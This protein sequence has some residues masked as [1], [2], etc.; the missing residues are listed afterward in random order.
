MTA[1]ILRTPEQFTDHYSEDHGLYVSISLTKGYYTV[2]R[3]RA[4][5]KGQAKAVTEDL[6]V[7]RV[8]AIYWNTGSADAAHAE[9]LRAGVILNSA[10]VREAAQ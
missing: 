9:V 8:I 4:H 10:S 1:T 7:A 2:Y 6:R 3:D 5:P